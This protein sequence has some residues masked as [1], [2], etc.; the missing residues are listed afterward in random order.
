MEEVI[1][2][3]GNLYHIEAP[4][5]TICGVRFIRFIYCRNQDPEIISSIS[6]LYITVASYTSSGAHDLNL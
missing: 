4:A 2:K 1:I 5:M 3:E 6:N